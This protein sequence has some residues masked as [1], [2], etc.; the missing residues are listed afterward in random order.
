VVVQKMIDE[1]QNDT[2]FFCMIW[3]LMGSYTVRITPE[4]QGYELIIWTRLDR[5]NSVKP[6]CDRKQNS[7]WESDFTCPGTI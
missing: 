5:T 6:T 4:V 7:S 1:E 2:T 3:L